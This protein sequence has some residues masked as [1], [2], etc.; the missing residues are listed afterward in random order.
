[1]WRQRSKCPINLIRRNSKADQSETVSMK[2]DF[3]DGKK[4]EPINHIKK[5]K[6]GNTMEEKDKRTPV[7]KETSELSF[8]RI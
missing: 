7:K 3:A 5:E 1:M 6:G 4:I 2:S 8:N